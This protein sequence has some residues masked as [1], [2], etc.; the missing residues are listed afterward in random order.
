MC[1][2]LDQQTL[3]LERCFEASETRQRKS[4]SSPPHFYF[5]LN[6]GLRRHTF[7][8]YKILTCIFRHVIWK[9]FIMRFREVRRKLLLLGKMFDIHEKKQKKK[10][11][12]T[13]VRSVRNVSRRFNTFD[14]KRQCFVDVADYF[15]GSVRTAMS[16][17]RRLKMQRTRLLKK[18]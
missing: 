4:T 16:R 17:K 11:R 3:W 8:L 14:V 5:L 1:I 9:C 12:D 2:V 10:K 7:V 13:F 6:S 18:Q 15:F